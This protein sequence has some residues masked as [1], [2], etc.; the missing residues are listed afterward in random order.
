MKG[1]SRSILLVLAAS[2]FIACGSGCDRYAKHK[3]LTFFFTG[4]PPLDDGGKTAEKEKEAGK[5]AAEEKKRPKRRSVVKATRFS[6]GPYASGACYLCHQI[7]ETGGF[8]G[9]AKEAK[10]AGSIAKPGIVPGKLVAP[11]RELCVGCHETK[12]PE[13]ARR[14]GLWVHGPVSAGLCTQ[15]HGPHSSPE[16][17]LLMKK[18]NALCLGCHAGGFIYN[19]V[20]HEEKKECLSC[21]N[22]HVGRN[23]HMLMAEH[24]ESW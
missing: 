19:K 6:H 14:N 8:R 1:R 12:S 2:L 17:Y 20:L 24:R 10:S 16:P 4:V 3:I 21:H 22:A 11:L 15:C 5:K 23:S 13:T 7:S 18:A 9:F